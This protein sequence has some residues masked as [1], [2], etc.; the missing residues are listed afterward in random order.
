MNLITDSLP[1]IAIGMEAGRNDVLKE[2]PRQANDS[3]LNK[4][5]FLQ[6]SYE[7]IVIAICTMCAYLTGL[8]GDPLTASTMAFATICLARLLHGFNCRSH[9]PLT[10][11]GFFTNRSS[12]IAFIIGFG[13]LHFI[14]FVP[15]MHGLFMIHTISFTQLFI[16]M[17]LHYY[18][19]LLFKQEK[20]LQNKQVKS[21]CLFYFSTFL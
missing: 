21:T 9:Q 5:T 16:I 20:C 15:A 2:K 3:I 7:G 6:I 8:K 1:A 10:K 4:T 11:I 18:Q 17:V 19:Q 13:L 12:I 14:L